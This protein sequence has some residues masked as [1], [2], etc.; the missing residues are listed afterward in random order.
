[1]KSI[2]AI[3]VLFTL[4]E[5]LTGFKRINDKTLAIYALESRVIRARVI[6]AIPKDSNWDG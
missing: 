4:T 1:M 2:K 6:P 3:V 5:D